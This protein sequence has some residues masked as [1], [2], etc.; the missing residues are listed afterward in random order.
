MGWILRSGSDQGGGDVRQHEGGYVRFAKKRSYYT[1]RN[2]KGVKK[3]RYVPHI[4]VLIPDPEGALTHRAYVLDRP[5]RTAYA[6][7]SQDQLDGDSQ[8]LQRWWAVMVRE[9]M[10]WSEPNRSAERARQE[11]VA[12]D[13]AETYQAEEQRKKEGGATSPP[14]RAGN[15]DATGPGFGLPEW[16]PWVA[17]AGLLAIGY[18]MWK[19]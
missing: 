6:R 3:I 11:Q 13:A 17:G 2:R 8:A 4:A 15:E 7:A 9:A 1:V 19:K 18:K 16:A 12:K 5:A 10:A 14:H